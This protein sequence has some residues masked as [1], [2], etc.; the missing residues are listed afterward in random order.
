LVIVR[1]DNC[2]EVVHFLF[3]GY[4]FHLRNEVSEFIFVDDS[5]VVVV[6]YFVK[7]NEFLKEFLMFFKLEIEDGLLELLERKF[8]VVSRV[9]LQ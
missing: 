4:Y 8:L 3:I 9:L 2:E 1:I 7:S 6:D 5:I